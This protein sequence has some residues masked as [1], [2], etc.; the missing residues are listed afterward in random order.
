MKERNRRYGSEN[1]QIEGG[2]TYDEETKETI[3]HL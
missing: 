3:Q 2:E 1:D